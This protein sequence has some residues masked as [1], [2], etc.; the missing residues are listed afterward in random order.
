MA[1][2]PQSIPDRILAAALALAAER[3][4]H[5]IALGEIAAQAKVTLAELHGAYRSKE[6][7]VMA[8]M[9]RTD[10]KV[11]AGVDPSAFSEL[12]RER[13]LDAVLRRLDALAPYKAAVGSMLRD[14]ALDP[15]AALCLAPAF[16]RSM[17]WTLE[18]A[19]IGSAGLSGRLKVKGLAA[20]YLSTL[21]V[22]IGDT[23]ADQG[24]TM[25]HLDRQLRRA[26]R[27]VSLLPGVH[28]SPAPAADSGP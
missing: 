10:D 1:R 11:I 4:W 23:S 28:R 8:L 17:V 5:D 6:A 27:L 16:L 19:G 20:I 18:S 21:R 24:R 22:W 3:R 15:I 9:A 26:E 12:P 14:T 2:R 25:A 7:I 13:L